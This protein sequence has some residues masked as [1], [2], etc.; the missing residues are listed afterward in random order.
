MKVSELIKMLQEQSQ[1][2]DVIYNDNEN[3]YMDVHSP[4]VEE[5]EDYQLDEKGMYDWKLPKIKKK[6]VL[7]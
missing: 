6:A 4:H 5:Y 2:L 1:D 3:G 7:L